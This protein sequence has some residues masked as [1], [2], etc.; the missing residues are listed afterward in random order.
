MRERL[1]QILN[2]PKDT[3]SIK[4]KTCEKLGDI[5]SGIALAVQVVSLVQKG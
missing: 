3:I 5:G 4:A 1:A 2:I